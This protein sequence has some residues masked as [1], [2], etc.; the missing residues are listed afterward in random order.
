MQC[1]VCMYVY[2]DVCTYV[3]QCY[4]W[5]YLFLLSHSDN[6]ASEASLPQISYVMKF[7]TIIYMVYIIWPDN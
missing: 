2:M 1:I 3:A 7:V 5:Q 6:L 4:T